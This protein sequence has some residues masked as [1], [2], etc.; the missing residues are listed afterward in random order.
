MYW[1]I[2]LLLARDSAAA[3]VVILFG[4]AMQTTT[5]IF[6]WDYDT[7]WGADRSRSPGVKSWGNHE[8]ENTK[9][10]L[11]LLAQYDIPACFGVV[12]AAALPGQ[13]PYH[14][15]AQIR[16]I[17]TAGHEIASHTH[18][19][20]WLPALRRAELLDTLRC[21]KEALEQCIGAPVIS[22]VPPF[23]QPFD[24]P[25]GW[26]FSLSERREVGRERTD[27]KRLCVA[28]RETGYRFCRVSYRPIHVRLAEQLFRREFNRPGQ[29]ETIAGIQCIR[30]N[31]PGGFGEAAQ[32]TIEAYL[33]RGGIWV[34]YGH[35]HSLHQS[36]SSQ[37]LEALQ[38]LLRHVLQWRSAGKVRCAQ[39]RD[40]VGGE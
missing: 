31:T 34:L 6:F 15:P 16:S 29:V 17:H 35:P 36:G 2:A 8:F 30:L 10:L 14:D 3:K 38:Q 18:R 26:S 12:G 11:D 19:H 5:L 22:F 23:N 24:Y 37:S 28:L 13:H 40:L 7:Q 39:P 9:V 27:L 4:R 21:S 1:P 25:A 32:R 20:E 33:G